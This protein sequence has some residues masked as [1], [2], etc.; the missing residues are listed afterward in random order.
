MEMNARA[1]LYDYFYIWP[2]LLI[3]RLDFTGV[4]LA[5]H[6]DGTLN[7]TGDTDKGWSL[8]VAIPW[9]NFFELA[10]T[11]APPQPGT[12][13]TAQLNRWDG[14]DP[15]RCLSQWCWSGLDWPGPHNPSRFGKL[16]FVTD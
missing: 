4:Q 10:G 13:W 12:I 14:V 7:V 15:N 6:I 1:T 2:Q 11:E 9:H 16:K 3:R 5:T 8:E